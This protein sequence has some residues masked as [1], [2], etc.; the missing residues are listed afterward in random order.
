MH[1]R[2]DWRTLSFDWNHARAFLVTAEEGSFSAAARALGMTQPTLGR[3]VSALEEDLGVTLFER[4]GRGLALTQAGR[5]L[6]T[7]MRQMGEAATAAALAAGGQQQQIEGHLAITASEIYASWLLPPIIA[8]LRRDAPG[9]TVEVIASNQIRDLKRREADIAIR[10]TRPEQADLIGKQIATDRATFFATPDYLRTLGPLRDPQDLSRAAFIGIDAPEGMIRALAPRGVVLESSNFPL[11]SDSHVVHWA[12]GRAG[13]GLCVGPC[14]LGDADTGLT[15][16]LADFEIEYPVW[17]VA[18]REL[19][20]NPR[21]R[22]AWDILA[23]AIPEL[24]KG[25]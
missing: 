20:T 1:I 6:L 12:M 25:P 13:L 18:H 15:R 7:H 24:L 2:M 23:E 11:G 8:R 21:I 19:R 17:L 22:L 3:Q 16:A 14:G 4:V 5:L 10:N 9:I